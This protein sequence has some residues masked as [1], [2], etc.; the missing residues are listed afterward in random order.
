MSLKNIVLYLGQPAVRVNSEAVFLKDDSEI[1]ADFVALATP[2]KP[3][4]WIKKLSL[5][6]D[7]QF[8]KI[9]DYLETSIPAVFACGDVAR[10]PQQV[11]P[12]AGVFAVRQAKT[13]THNLLAAVYGHEKMKYKPQKRYLNLIMDGQGK[14]L[15]SRGKL[16][17]PNSKIMWKLKNFIDQ[18]FLSKFNQ[19]FD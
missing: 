2:V 16:F 17:F 9:N 13:L 7:Q 11:V 18:K 4:A 15:A 1:K 3:Q 12:R 19:Q 10:N 5:V 8:I 6:H 14:A